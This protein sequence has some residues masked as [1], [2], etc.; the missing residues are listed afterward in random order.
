MQRC[1]NT[2]TSPAMAMANSAPASRHT[3]PGDGQGGNLVCGLC[4]NTYR[5]P[6]LLPC[7]HTFCLLCL[8][9]L[10]EEKNPGEDFPCPDHSCRTMLQ[11]P[12]EGARG[13]MENYYVAEQLGEAM[14]FDDSVGSGVG[15]RWARTWE[16]G[17]SRKNSQRSQERTNSKRDVLRDSWRRQPTQKGKEAFK[18]VWN[19]AGEG[20]Q[21]APTA[22]VHVP[23]A[24]QKRAGAVL[25]RGRGGRLLLV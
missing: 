15:S 19:P 11:V 9:R 3:R 4:R 22:A 16:A 12:Q 7:Y 6:K 18:E 24:S 2:E 13:F 25:R 21:T 8:D 1:H 10:L 23:R 5:S 14:N 17:T 20:R